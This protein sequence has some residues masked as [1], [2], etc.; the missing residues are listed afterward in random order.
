MPTKTR[1][2]NK[3]QWAL[4]DIIMDSVEAQR[5]WQKADERADASMDVVLVRSLGRINARL[6]RIE[7][8]AR[9]ALA[10]EYDQR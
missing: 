9:M 7:R 8:T 3:T 2:A 4:N 6:A 10:G 5:A 1:I